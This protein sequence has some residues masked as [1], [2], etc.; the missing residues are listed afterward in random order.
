MS[1]CPRRLEHGDP[2]G[3]HGDDTAPDGHCRY[4][5]GLSGDEVMRRI[6][7]GEQVIPTDK[8]YKIY[9][10]NAKAYFQHLSDVQ[11]DRFV[12]ILNAKKMNIGHPGYFYVRPYFIAPPR[13]SVDNGAPT[14]L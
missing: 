14:V 4:C 12:E 5:G 9:L 8:S 2:P 10:E 13:P 6:E 1:L 3:D 7:A 11:M